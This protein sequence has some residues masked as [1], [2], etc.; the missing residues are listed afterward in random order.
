MDF[1][2]VNFQ[3]GQNFLP[4]PPP[5]EP[6][7]WSLLHALFSVVTLCSHSY[8]LSSG[9]R[10]EPRTLHPM[11]MKLLTKC[12]QT[13]AGKVSTVLLVVCMKMFLDL[14]SRK[15]EQQPSMQC[16]RLDFRLMVCSHQVT[17]YL[18]I[19]ICLLARVNMVIGLLRYSIKGKSRYTVWSHFICSFWSELS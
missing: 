5:L 11:D 18:E 8:I 9:T 17:D 10:E 4:I 13:I 12:Q 15:L 1:T 2:P 16:L 14:Y 19:L 6:S 7:L 3:N